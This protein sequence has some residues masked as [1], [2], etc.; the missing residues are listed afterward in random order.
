MKRIKVVHLIDYMG[1]GGAEMMLLKLLSQMD[2]DRFE[3]FVISMM[4]AGPVGERIMSLG[5]PVHI[6]GMRAGKPSPTAFLKLVRLLRFMQ[7]DVLQTWMVNANLAGALGGRLAGIQNLIW[8]I[9]GS[10]LKT[11]ECSRMTALAIRICARLSKWPAVVLSNSHAGLRACES[12]GYYSKRWL[13][14]PNGFDLDVFHPDGNARKSVREELDLHN[15]APL[16]GIVGRFHPMKDHAT[17]VKAAE[18]MHSLRPDVRF[19]MVGEGLTPHNRELREMAP[20]LVASNALHLLGVRHDIPRLLSALDVFSL[21]SHGGEG[22]PNVVGEAM[23]CGVPCVV[24]NMAGDAP[25]IVG[26][27]GIVVPAKRP[28]AL[29]AAWHRLLTMPSSARKALGHA[30]LDKVSRHYSIAAI[31][32]LYEQVYLQSFSD[33]I[34][35]PV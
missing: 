5:L 24:T 28:A 2:R 17:F 3:S 29:A 21:T 18:R 33:E 16:I 34:R 9:R 23:A 7:P 30:A 12:N 22:F 11:G 20:R 4:P 13:I 1:L 14:I 25:Q 10:E 31:V 19:L 8:N 6:L 35:V 27:T 32:R 15:E 26:D